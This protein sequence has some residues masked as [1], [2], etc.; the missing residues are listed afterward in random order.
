MPRLSLCSLALLTPL[1][2]APALA[3]SP[4]GGSIGAGV[5]MTPDYLGSNDYTSRAVPDI[6][7]NYG[8]FAYLSWRDGLGVN[9]YQQQN[10]TISPF[11]GYHVGRD[12][13][14]DISAFE[15]VDAGMTAGVR[16]SYQPSAWRYS[17][18]AQAP[19][20]G[21]VDGYKVSLRADLQEQI[22]PKWYVGISPSLSYSSSAWTKDMFNVSARDSARSGLKQ[23]QAS[24][25]YLR[26]GLTG[27]VSYQFA[28]RWTLTGVAGVTQ[29]TGDAKDSPIVKQVGD[30][31]QVLTGVVL[32]Y[33]F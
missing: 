29:L 25:G 19:V 11:L 33:N 17:I 12:N 27:N 5:M 10:W 32:N 20:T 14:G 31:T 1:L 3:Q 24:E 16:V 26:L 21:D 7:L 4:W 13:E 30:A 22:A 9:L 2:A 23:Y 6:E 28:Q 18:K 15:K 8:D